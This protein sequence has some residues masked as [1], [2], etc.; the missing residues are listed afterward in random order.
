MKPD[1]SII[2]AV[3]KHHAIG[4]A[5]S[6]PFHIGPDLK[7]FKAL[8]MGKPVVMGRKTFESLPGGALPGR[9]NI[10]VTRHADYQPEGAETAPTL[11]GALA[12]A[13]GA[14]VEEIMVIGGGEIYAQA[15]PLANRIYLTEVEAHYPDADTF[16]PWVDFS[17]WTTEEVSEPFHDERS[18]LDYRFVILRRK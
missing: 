6:I 8:T 4:A 16:F 15:L 14:G 5:G 3:A 10:V 17:E 11:E 13:A 7:R 9:R 1:I 12:M 2:V 18:G